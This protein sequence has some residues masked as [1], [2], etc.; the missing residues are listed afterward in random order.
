LKKEGYYQYAKLL[1]AQGCD[2]NNEDLEARR[3]DHISH[4]VLRL[5]YSLEEELQNY[6]IVHETEFFKLR[7]TSLNKEGLSQ[8]LSTS[9]IHYSQ[10][11]N[12]IK[13]S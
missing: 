1:N 6:M 7:F 12:I 3:K 2:S 10:V 8:F 13:I 9:G 5:A 4:Y 11:N